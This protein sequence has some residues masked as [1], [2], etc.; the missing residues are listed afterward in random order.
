MERQGVTYLLDSVILIDHLNDIRASTQFL[1]KEHLRCA[2]SAITRAEV[3]TGLEAAAREAAA[4]LLDFFPCLP[5]TCTDAD[6]AATLRRNHGWKL[7][8]AIQAA[9]AQRNRLKLATRNS[10]DFDP[11]RHPFVVFPYRV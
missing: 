5:L 2:I 7:P 9:L 11:Q 1:A 8:D 4:E 6:L 3:L 10:R